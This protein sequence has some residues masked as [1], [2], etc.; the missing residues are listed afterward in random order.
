MNT[1]TKGILQIL[2]AVLLLLVILFLSK[3][4]E[5]LAGFGY[6]GVFLISLL[7]SATILFPAPGWVA[8]IAISRILDPIYVGLIA[9]FGSGLG[10]ITGY[11]AG[12]GV[13]SIINDEHF[14]KIKSVIE[15]YDIFAIFFLSFIPNPLFDIAG[16]AAGS[17]GM[18][19]WKFLIACITGRVLRYLILAYLGRF[20]IEFL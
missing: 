19:W 14:T 8:V 9:G 5:K 11:I 17:V 10:E 7:S 15:K 3:D 13:N 6:I 12:S 20:S 16:I 18:K 1:K 4:I 2:L